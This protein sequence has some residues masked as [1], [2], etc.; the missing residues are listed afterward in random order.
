MSARDKV[1]VVV[2]TKKL[3]RLEAAILSKRLSDLFQPYII[4][5]GKVKKGRGKVLQQF[6]I[7]RLA[8]PHDRG[9][10][11][12]ERKKLLTTPNV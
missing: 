6:C 8:S 1:E 5:A 11:T 12:I 2:V 4:E 10:T 3:Y 7:V 9:T